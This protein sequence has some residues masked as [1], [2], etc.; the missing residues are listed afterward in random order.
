MVCYHSGYNQNHTYVFTRFENS[1]GDLINDIQFLEYCFVDE[2]GKTHNVHQVVN[3]LKDGNTK[4]DEEGTFISMDNILGFN[5]GNGT[6]L[7]GTVVPG[8]TSFLEKSIDGDSIGNYPCRLAIN[9]SYKYLRN[10]EFDSYENSDGTTSNSSKYEDCNYLLYFPSQCIEKLVYINIWWVTKTE[11]GTEEINRG[12]MSDY[13]VGITDDGTE[14]I[15]QVSNKALVSSGLY[16]GSDG[17]VYNQDGTPTINWEDQMQGAFVI[18]NN[19]SGFNWGNP[20]DN[21]VDNINSGTSN[22]LNILTILFSIILTLIVI[23]ILS[24]IIKLIKKIFK[25]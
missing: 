16:V 23:Y 3:T 5:N 15:Y 9:Y 24:L 11:D 14:N 21:F 1:N 2:E 13:A 19:D 6:I 10:L 17:I 20:F 18:E 7:N 8:L 22:F 4:Y 25:K 12:S